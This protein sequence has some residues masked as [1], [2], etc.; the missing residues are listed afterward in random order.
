[1]KKLLLLKDWIRLSDAAEHL[2]II[3]KEP[4]TDLDILQLAFEL[5]IVLS[6][7]I[8]QPVTARIVNANIDGIDRDISTTISINELKEISGVF[9]LPLIGDEIHDIQSSFVEK[10]GGSSMRL[11]QLRGVFVNSLTN[12]LFQLIELT[13]PSSEISDV[14]PLDSNAYDLNEE[15]LHK[16]FTA[17]KIRLEEERNT[18]KFSRSAAP[19]R[20]E[21]YLQTNA[22]TVQIASAENSLKGVDTNPPRPGYFL[23]PSLP[24]GSL[25]V[26]RAA[27]LQ[28][29]QSELTSNNLVDQPQKLLELERSSLLKMVLGMAV[30][31]YGY[32]P[33]AARNSA[34]GENKGS[35][36]ADLELLGLGLDAETVRKFIK[37]AD[38][39]F[40]DV[41]P[42]T[43][44]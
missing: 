11:T 18:P 1:M 3:L 35:I 21:D 25:L 5:K 23:A 19:S 24:K 15:R 13:E 10:I 37:E 20:T 2:S 29:Y 16:N 38:E 12:E 4:V 39:K 33:S 43:K 26:M 28:K 41:L 34:T 27:N 17:L 14:L 36:Y 31:K 9:D 7:V 6:I 42:S 8:F 44:Q 40:R 22:A 30:S 32:R